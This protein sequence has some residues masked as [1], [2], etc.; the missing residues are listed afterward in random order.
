[1]LSLSEKWLGQNGGIALLPI[2]VKALKS[3][4][5]I[6]KTLTSLI[7]LSFFLPICILFLINPNSFLLLDP[8]A[9]SYSWKGR[10][11][12][13]F[14]MWLFF[15][16]FMMAWDKVVLKNFASIKRSRL[17]ALSMT[18]VIP[19]AYVIGTNIL[20][21]NEVVIEIGKHLGIAAGGFLEFHWPL[22]LEY[23][24]L[25][26]LFTISVWLAYNVD[27]L[28]K[29]SVSL[30]FLGA[31]GTV[32]MIDT[33]YPYGAF[34]VF[35]AVV[36]I[37]TSSASQVLTW[38]GYQ[39]YIVP[40]PTENMPTLIVFD[41]TDPLRRQAAYAIG[42]PCAGIQSLFIYTFAMLLF[43]KEAPFGLRRD[44]ICAAISGRSKLIARIESIAYLSESRLFNTAKTL[45]L[46]VL[47]L[48]PFFTIF[49]VGALGTYMVNILRIV[50]IFVVTI[51]AGPQGQAAGRT[52]HDYFGE[53]YSLTW[54][55]VY[56]TIV[57]LIAA[58]Y[59]RSYSAP[60]RAP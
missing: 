52:F 17:I 30:F 2:E 42:W 51:N 47:G 58:R 56:L 36:P 38:M 48:L 25:A 13:L 60:V 54:I 15:L 18:T 22:S 23:L 5:N 26:T 4:A 37:T 34:V 6:K 32:Y 12:Y 59:K 35:Q 27:G 39:T 19:I 41:P 49:A 40:N 20:G 50:T 16:E 28:K 9:L 53:L 8:T 14:F 55:I 11:A 44:A 24:V 3:S 31:I 10:I 1:M 43:L 45:F 57:A 29:F 7:P 33:F 46:N 21:L